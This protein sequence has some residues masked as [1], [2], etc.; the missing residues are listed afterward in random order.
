MDV[1]GAVEFRVEGAAFVPGFSFW[2]LL[3]VKL[4]AITLLQEGTFGN[5][6]IFK[7]IDSI[8]EVGRL[9]GACDVIG[10]I[11]PDDLTIRHQR[12]KNSRLQRSAEIGA[13]RDRIARL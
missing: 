3:N 2:S 6:S 11:C 9:I 7:A 10:L 4:P 1:R 8:G 12:K 5:L 13:N